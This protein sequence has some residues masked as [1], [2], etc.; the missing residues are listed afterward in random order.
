M[1]LPAMRSLAL[2]LVAASTAGCHEPDPRFR[3]A[4]AAQDTLHAALAQMANDLNTFR[5]Q[6]DEISRRLAALSDEVPRVEEAL[7]DT[8]RRLSASGFKTSRERVTGASHPQSRRAW[9]LET[10]DRVEDSVLRLV[11]VLGGSTLL[12]LEH[13]ERGPGACSALVTAPTVPAVEPR[14]PDCPP[15]APDLPEPVNGEERALRDRS[16]EKAAELAQL[17]TIIADVGDLRARR[18]ELERWNALVAPL[19]D[20]RQLALEVIP[21]L[22]ADGVRAYGLALEADRAGY[23]LRVPE[24]PPALL[25][26][27]SAWKGD[28]G[29]GAPTRPANGSTLEVSLRLKGGK[30]AV[31]GSR[32]VGGGNG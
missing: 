2:A 19:E 17:C 8:T 21:K 6:Q 5:R 7:D 11:E 18:A 29:S 15:R 14:E 9:R 3:E 4:L 23:V 31:V 32:V 30:P 10:R 13:F 22:A 27:L 12:T 20:L 26:R 24:P 16:R 25:R 28:D 1:R